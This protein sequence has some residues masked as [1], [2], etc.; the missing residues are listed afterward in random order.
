[1]GKFRMPILDSSEED[2][3]LQTRSFLNWVRTDQKFVANHAY[4]ACLFYNRLK[5]V[6]GL[7]GA[8]IVEYFGGAGI[9]AVVAENVLSP[10]NHVCID[11]HPI[12]VEQLKLISSAY[13]KVQVFQDDFEGWISR[14]R[15]TL[16]DIHD[17]DNPRFT[18]SQ[19]R[20]YHMEF[21]WIFSSRPAVVK[22]ADVAGRK[23]CWNKKYFQKQFGKQ[24]ETYNDYLRELSHSIH[25]LFGYSL[26]FAY[27]YGGIA[28]MCLRE[29]WHDPEIIPLLDEPRGFVI[30]NGLQKSQR[31]A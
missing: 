5:D 20:Y 29:G 9:H 1:M 10:R 7:E 17:L 16:F 13:P 18:A 3:G 6:Y 27:T 21:S 28:L 26:S 23:M 8:S 31:N 30:E 24:I 19:L 12:A 25:W 14:N 11:C 22:M 2:G 15:D 4:A